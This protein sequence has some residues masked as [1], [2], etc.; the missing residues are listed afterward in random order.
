MRTELQTKLQTSF[1]LKEGIRT[2]PELI[3]RGPGSGGVSRPS[4]EQPEVRV[5]VQPVGGACLVV[6]I[7]KM[8]L[9]IV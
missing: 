6:T 1:R 2:G 5:S 7:S 4:L 8:N 9:D 3:S